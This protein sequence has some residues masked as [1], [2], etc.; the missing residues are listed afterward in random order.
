MSF[1]LA[2]HLHPRKKLTMPLTE[3]MPHNSN[4]LFSARDCSRPLARTGASCVFGV[5]AQNLL[6]LVPASIST[7]CTTCA[8]LNRDHGLTRVDELALKTHTLRVAPFDPLRGGN[9]SSPRLMSVPTVLPGLEATSDDNIPKTEQPLD[10]D[11]PVASEPAETRAG[12]NE[13]QAG[14]EWSDDEKLFRMRYLELSSE[15]D[16]QL[17]FANT[18]ALRTVATEK[19]LWLKDRKE[20]RTA[21]QHLDNA[22]A[23]FK[24]LHDFLEEKGRLELVLDE[25]GIYKKKAPEDAMTERLGILK[26]MCLAREEADQS[27]LQAQDIVIEVSTMPGLWN[28][29]EASST[30]TLFSCMSNR[31]LTFLCAFVSPQFR[32]QCS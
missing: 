4:R 7:G 29:W 22:K 32:R 6:R 16:K 10:A 23:A 2:L 27:A 9:N 17:A 30:R 28:P 25:N 12:Q 11:V 15:G 19:R 8:L 5:E 20:L 14:S 21:I 1:A 26:G 3:S 13:Q 24:T 18:A 31:F